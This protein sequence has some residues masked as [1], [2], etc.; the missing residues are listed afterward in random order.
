MSADPLSLA[1][2]FLACADSGSFSAAGRRLGISRSSVGKAI[3]KL[4]AQLGARLIRRTTRSQSL[5]EDG[6][7]Y[8][9]RARRAVIELEAAQAMLESK[10]HVPAGVLKVTAPV[11]L[12]RR[13]ITRLLLSLTAKHAALK[14]A[15][16]LTDRPIDL[17]EEG[18]DLAIRVGEVTHSDGLMGRRIGRQAMVICAAPGYLAVRGT[19]QSR[20]DLAAHDLL[21][22][23]RTDGVRKWWLAE[24]REEAQIFATAA[25][26][27]LDDL[28]ALADAAE[29]GLGLACLPSWLVRDRLEAGR[30][31]QVLPN[32]PLLTYDVAAL[33]P[34][35]PY[36]P[37]RLRAAL[38]LLVAELPAMLL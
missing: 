37:A 14:L 19:P 32:A 23:G 13:C 21:I 2:I 4:E 6:H 31:T 11:V 8:Y 28:D 33:W 16:S 27:R 5:T 7:I 34:V 18:Y 29:M 22:Y 26:I 15:V 1:S 12:G 35:G 24:T 20:A 10:R 30:L 9:E 25:R 3:A 17:V 36:M 38:D